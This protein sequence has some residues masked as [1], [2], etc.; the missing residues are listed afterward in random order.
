MCETSAGVTASF[1]RT[2]VFGTLKS[3]F[4]KAA[5]RKHDYLE[6]DAVTPQHIQLKLTDM[7]GHFD[8]AAAEFSAPIT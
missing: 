3:S 5:P 6:G 8:V 1:T 2:V 7:L 4:S